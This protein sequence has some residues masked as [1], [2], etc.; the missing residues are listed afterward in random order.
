MCKDCDG[1]TIPIGPQG[2][3]GIPGETGENG[4]DGE[5]GTN[6]TNGVNGTTILSSY[7][8]LLGV[9][10]PDNTVETIL[11]SYVVPLNTLVNNGDELELFTYYEYFENDPVTLRI[12]FGSKVVT[13]VV[14]DSENDIRVLKIK[15]SRISQT[16]QMWV[17]QEDRK[18]L[19]VVSGNLLQ[20]DSSTVDLATNLTFQITAQNS[21][22]GANQLVLKKATLYKYSI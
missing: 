20:I 21:A 2:P 7:N 17:I 19:S 12:K 4:T 6:G 10:T 18:I 3:Q 13:L 8:N 16:S 14:A 15:I 9:G 1:L 11:Y 5:D 22:V